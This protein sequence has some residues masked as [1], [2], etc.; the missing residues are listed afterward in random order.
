ML[1][2]DSSRHGPT[3]LLS[4][5]GEHSLLNS[6]LPKP[7]PNSPRTSNPF[8]PV[9]SI[10]S[11]SLPFCHLVGSNMPP[12]SP[13]FPGPRKSPS[14][15]QVP[16]LK[17]LDHDRMPTFPIFH[18]P[19]SLEKEV[20]KQVGEDERNKLLGRDKM[21][22]TLQEVETS[23]ESHRKPR[24][25]AWSED[26]KQEIAT[27]DH[28][29]WNLIYEDNLEDIEEMVR[30][31]WKDEPSLRWKVSSSL[32]LL[33]QTHGSHSLSQLSHRPCNTLAGEPDIKA[34]LKQLKLKVKLPFSSFYFPDIPDNFDCGRLRLKDVDWFF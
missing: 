18:A 30:E 10:F 14:K 29:D 34:N 13:Y 23:L 22:R 27:P 26:L 6:R 4:T 17:P 15:E 24:Y 3:L 19:D 1:E 21:N 25:K 12:P 7:D 8:L 20:E 31:V 16:P 11:L 33:V 2:L 28:P 9:E 5:P 32:S